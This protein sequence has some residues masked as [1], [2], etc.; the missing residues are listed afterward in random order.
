MDHIRVK[1]RGTR[2][3]VG[4]GL[5]LRTPGN[6]TKVNLILNAHGKW[7]SKKQHEQGKLYGI[8]NIAPYIKRRKMSL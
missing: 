6:L 1:K 2:Q 7:V 3:E 5:A 8:L 4:E